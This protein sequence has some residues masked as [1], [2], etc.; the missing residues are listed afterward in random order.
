MSF[1]VKTIGVLR[2]SVLTPTYYSERFD[3]LEK[4]AA[5]L[6]SPDRMALRFRLF[7]QL[8]LPS[9]T[10]QSD[11]DFD[12]VVLT[13]ESMP[14]RYLDKLRAL[15]DPYPNI[16]C[17]PVGTQK[18][19]GL[20][21]AGFNSIPV[22]DATHRA[23]FRLD[24]DDAV[25]VDFIGRTKL[26]ANAMLDMQ[27]PDIP[28]VIAYNRGFYVRGTPDGNEVFDACEHSPLSTGTTLV[29]SLDHGTNPYRFNHRKMAQHYN[30][31]SDISV[32][33]FIRTVH[34]DNKSNPKQMGIT[35][36]MEPGDIDAQLRLHFDTTLDHLL[37]L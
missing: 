26:I 24:D 32:P 3:T 4:T 29:A 12:T 34:G 31:F 22:G 9:L 1:K 27:G 11:P 36:K 2:F 17:R 18:H 33:G 15:L 13:A 28:F 8:C 23:M 35:H 6:F 37:A 7:E 20:L 19:Y 14:P 25:D 5:H 21:K 10:R 16:H 30:T